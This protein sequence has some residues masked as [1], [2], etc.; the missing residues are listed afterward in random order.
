MKNRI[1][2]DQK[3]LNATCFAAI[4]PQRNLR[5]STIAA[6]YLT[7]AEVQLYANLIAPGEP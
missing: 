2:R 1:K 5:T 7:Q 3:D 4:L 6:S